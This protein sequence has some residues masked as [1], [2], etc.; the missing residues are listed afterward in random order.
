MQSLEK[1]FEREL[2]DAI[3][4]VGYKDIFSIPL[5]EECKS[6]EVSGTEVYAVRGIEEKPY[7]GL[8][9]TIVKRLPKDKVAKRRVVD[10]VT[11]KWKLDE[12]GN[13]VYEDYPVP[14]GSVVVVSD[15]KLGVPYKLY[16]DKGSK[17]GYIDYTENGLF[18]YVLPKEVL[19][20]VN[21]TALVISVK[22]MKNYRGMGYT[23]WGKGTIFIH[24][25]PYKPNSSQLYVGSKVLK[26]GHTLNYAEEIKTILRYWQKVN[27]IPCLSLT[28][29][30]NGE[31][32]AI[33]ETISG[34]DENEYIP[35]SPLPLGD[36]EVYTGEE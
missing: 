27:L 29:L 35:V 11:R 3:S 20:R 4:N 7:D 33:K 9:K 13:Y 23:T 25:V 12:E 21:Q 28:A 31:N 2:R 32:L 36:K 1:V 24:I 15:K 30:S 8:N 14:S 19:Y 10:K 34:Y 5:P 26:T 6:W 16:I 18:M 17:Y 22:N